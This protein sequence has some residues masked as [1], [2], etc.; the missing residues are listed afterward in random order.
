LV[1][2]LNEDHAS[3]RIKAERERQK[4]RKCF[5]QSKRAK[6]KNKQQLSKKL[7]LDGK[8]HKANMVCLRKEASEKIFQSMDL[9]N[10]V[11]MLK[12]TLLS[13]RE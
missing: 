6:A 9:A 12:I 2:D 5:Q 1:I 4:M 8:A 10:L 3:L 7:A 13:Y 11:C